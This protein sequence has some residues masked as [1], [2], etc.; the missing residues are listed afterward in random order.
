MTSAVPPPSPAL[1]VCT[2]LADWVMTLLRKVTPDEWF[3]EMASLVSHTVLLDMLPDPPKLK[4]PI[5]PESPRTFVTLLWLKSDVPPLLAEM[6][7]RKTLF[8]FTS[9]A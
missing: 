1:S 3:D 8:T 4:M 7:R 6:P 9:W 5:E 2:P